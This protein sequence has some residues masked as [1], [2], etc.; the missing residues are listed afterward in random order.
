MKEP[1]SAADNRRGSDE[2]A[3]AGCGDGGSSV[4]DSSEASAGAGEAGPFTP[5]AWALLPRV[6]LACRPAD[7]DECDDR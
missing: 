6:G 1:A 7:L 4:A 2:R 5:A 3:G